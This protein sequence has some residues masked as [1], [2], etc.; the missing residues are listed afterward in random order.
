MGLLIRYPNRELQDII[1]D[2]VPEPLKEPIS[3]T[4]HIAIDSI[5]NT[6]LQ[7]RIYLKVSI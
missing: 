1:F 3:K 5:I 4:G 7:P 2:I 6:K